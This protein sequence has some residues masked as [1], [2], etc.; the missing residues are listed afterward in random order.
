M[1][2]AAATAGTA[3]GEAYQPAAGA[4]QQQQYL[5]QQ[6]P[7]SQQQSP[8]QQPGRAGVAPPQLRLLSPSPQVVN[9]YMES[10]QTLMK[11]CKQC[12]RCVWWANMAPHSARKAP[13]ITCLAQVNTHA[14]VVA[15]PLT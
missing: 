1:N 9:Q 8:Q 11:L 14:Y 12:D 7:L 5:Q 6:Q 3:A 2:T 13:V 10:L 15:C 4:P